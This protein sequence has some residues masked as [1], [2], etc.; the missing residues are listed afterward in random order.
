M[1]IIIAGA[2]EVG[3]YLAKMLSIERHEIVVID[4]D[5]ERLNSLDSHLEVMTIRGSSASIETLK[6]AEVCKSDLFI[7]V[8]PTEELNIT[9]SILSKKLGACKTIARIDNPEYLKST[10]KELFKGM[11]ID[12]LIYP[13]QLAAK[14]VVGLLNQS[15]TTEV[16]DF[17]GGKLTLIVVRLGDNAPIINRTLLEATQLNKGLSYRAVAITRD[18]NT[19]VPRGNE[20]FK[21]N[22]VVYVITNQTGIS[23]L[24]KFSGK[25]KFHIRNIM[26]V[27][28]S[29]IGAQTARVLQNRSNIKL[30]EIDRAKSFD[31]ADNLDKTMVIRG[32]GSDMDLLVE[33]GIKEMDAFIAVTGNSETNI[34]SCLQAKK[35][36]VKKTIAEVENIEYIRLAENIGIDSMINK[37]FIAASHIFGFTMNAL[38]S[39]VKCLT[40]TDA[41][42]LE[43]RPNEGSEIT[44]APL[45]DLNFPDEAIV[46]GIIRGKSGFIASG[47]TLIRPSDKVIVFTLP[48]AIPRV[49]RFFK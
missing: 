37:K 38:I 15:G 8:T 35:L 28:G 31:L 18:G 5:N 19:I 12:S 6:E 22:D 30:I 45:K 16:V 24:M 44:K 23:K 4:T 7:S 48:S 25:Q 14:E 43:I 34:L 42:L 46:G 29:R 20:V 10:H 49:E 39:S 27:G 17:S 41:E 9:S 40:G 2:G 11:G 3:T 13:E 32:D 36:G 1:K 26:I 47:D 33:E 21:V